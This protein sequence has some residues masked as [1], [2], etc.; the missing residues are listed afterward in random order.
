MAPRTLTHTTEHP[1]YAGT[2]IIDYTGQDNPADSVDGTYPNA[3][4]V[5]SGRRATLYRAVDGEAPAVVDS[6]TEC[7]YIE[8]G[9]T[10][11]ITGVSAF[12]IE[13]VKVDDDDDVC[14]ATI[15]IE[16]GECQGCR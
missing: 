3:W 8:D 2:A 7:S 15:I 16:I 10:I 5:C 9:K 13:Q 12:L 4:A 14:M 11:T 6:F 1:M